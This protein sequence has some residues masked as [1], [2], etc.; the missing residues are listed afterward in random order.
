MSQSGH[1]DLDALAGEHYVLV[2]EHPEHGAVVSDH[3]ATVAELSRGADLDLLAQYLID[4]EERVGESPR[5]SLERLVE[6][7]NERRSR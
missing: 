7:V 5:E 2:G 6:A 4:R 3:H 1:V